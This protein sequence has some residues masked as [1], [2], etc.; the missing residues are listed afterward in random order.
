MHVK[1]TSF[2]THDLHGFHLNATVMMRM[3]SA[4][5]VVKVTSATSLNDHALLKL[6]SAIL[7]KLMFSSF[8]TLQALSSSVTSRR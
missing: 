4:D 7:L 3:M 2:R 6:S 1:T 5:V 8:W